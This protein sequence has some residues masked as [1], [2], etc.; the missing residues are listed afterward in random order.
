VDELETEIPHNAEGGE[1]KQVEVSCEQVV[2]AERSHQH[3]H[4]NCE[5]D[6]VAV[7]DFEE[8]FLCHLSFRFSLFA[9]EQLGCE[10]MGGYAFPIGMMLAS[11]TIVAVGTGADGEGSGVAP[12]GVFG[13]FFIFFGL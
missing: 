7:H 10:L 12:V 6:H 5:N 11:A 2:N 13:V 9:F 3:E 1:G 8:C 4:D